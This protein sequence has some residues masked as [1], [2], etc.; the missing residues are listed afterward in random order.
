[1]NFMYLSKFVANSVA[2]TAAA[3][4]S[5]RDG[6]TEIRQ[7]QALR[8]DQVS[9]ELPHKGRILSGFRYYFL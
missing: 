1:M 7:H 6:Q 3:D 2:T 9:A 8:E 4:A 5:E